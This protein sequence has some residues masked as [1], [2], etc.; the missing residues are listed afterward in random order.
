MTP[1]T[2]TQGM[3]FRQYYVAAIN[4]GCDREQ[5]KSIARER[6]LAAIM[7]GD[8]EVVAVRTRIADNPGR[9]GPRG[10]GPETHKEQP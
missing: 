7:R 6:L 1:L 10:K 2:E 3:L 4:G 9:E 5:A 8:A